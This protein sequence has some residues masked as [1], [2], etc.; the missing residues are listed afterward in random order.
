LGFPR[1]IDG[2]FRERPHELIKCRPEAVQ[3][4]PDYQVYS[5]RGICGV[6]VND[7]DSFF[8]IILTDKGIGFRFIKGFKLFPESFKVFL[9]PT[10]LQI[11][12]A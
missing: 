10:C 7:M 2:E 4:I 3:D 5:I 6:N 1:V 11:G 9:R 12:I 8:N